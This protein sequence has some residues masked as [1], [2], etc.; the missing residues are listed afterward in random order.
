MKTEVIEH[1]LS[2]GLCEEMAEII[3]DKI[4]NR[5]IHIVLGGISIFSVLHSFYWEH[6]VEGYDYWDSFYT[7]IYESYLF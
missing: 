4:V 2:L 1:L 6:S 3:A 7:A 5:R